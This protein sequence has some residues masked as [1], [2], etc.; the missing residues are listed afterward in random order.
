MRSDV[1]DEGHS[2]QVFCEK[3]TQPATPDLRVLRG[4]ERSFSAEQLIDARDM[5]AIASRHPQVDIFPFEQAKSL[6][7]QGTGGGWQFSLVLLGF[8]A[9]LCPQGH[10]DECSWEMAFTF[11]ATANSNCD[12]SAL[13]SMVKPLPHSSAAGNS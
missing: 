5:A 11:A 4:K 3:F 6:R 7:G 8:R 9:F 13:V 10:M 1:Q 12:L 2:E